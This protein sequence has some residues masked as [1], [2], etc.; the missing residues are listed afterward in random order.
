MGSED[1]GLPAARVPGGSRQTAKQY[2]EYA[3]AR[4][5][6]GLLRVLP[7]RLARPA[8]EA[9]GLA[10]GRIVR[11][12][13]TVAESNLRHALPEL[14]ET[15]RLQIRQDACR[16]LGRVALALAQAPY[17][18]A[19]DVRQH[20][21][22][23]GLEHFRDAEANGRGV[24][25]LTAHLGNWE[26]GALA[27]GAVVGPLHVMV[28]PIENP[29]VDRLVERRRE[30]HAN[31]VIRKRNAAR[32]VLAVLQRNGTVGI[33][34]DQNTTLKEAVFV[35]FLGRPAATN[36]GLAWLALRSGAAV[37][38]AFAWW[39]YETLRHIVEYGPAIELSRTGRRSVDLATNSQLFQNAL[40]ERIRRHPDQWLWMHRRWKTRPLDET[41][42]PKT[43]ALPQV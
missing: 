17:W 37:V 41:A 30:A 23:V 34:A 1:V 38:P 9:L 24:L 7:F 10:C 3:A 31:R 32:Q 36:K 27:H 16:N 18:S 42:V 2:F 22:F 28:R 8:A 35:S 40:E 4:G 5:L 43:G 12:W 20:V 33:L 15:A 19:R 39:D 21:D 11:R 25:L 6:L 26:L 13:R 29:L 14:S